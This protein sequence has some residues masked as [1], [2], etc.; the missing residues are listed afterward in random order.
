MIPIQKLLARIRWDAQFAAYEDR[1]DCE[2]KRLSLTQV[3]IYPRQYLMFEIAGDFGTFYNVPFH[4][5]RE[6]WHDGVLIW[7][8]RSNKIKDK[9]K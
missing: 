4:R 5:I 7:G 1:F 3:F 2:L 6:V 8:R 9:M